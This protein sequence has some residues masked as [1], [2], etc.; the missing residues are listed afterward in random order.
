VSER[1]E[2][3]I[4]SGLIALVAVAVV[5]GLLAGIAA[6]AG[7]RLLGIGGAGSGGSGEAGAGDSL[8]MPAVV[9][10][11]QESGPLVTL[12][13]DETESETAATVTESETATETPTQAEPTISLT[14]GSTEVAAGEELRLSGL[15]REGEGAVLDIFYN[16]NNG[17]WEEFPLDVNVSGGIFEVYVQTWKDGTIKWRVED[18]S[19][20]RVSNAITVHHG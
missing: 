17:G 18:A 1:E 16:V 7:T 8:F 10:T 14:A 15:Y 13:A 12:P 20:H 3:P 11:T 6:L 5:V 4:A 9:P 19:A 2:N